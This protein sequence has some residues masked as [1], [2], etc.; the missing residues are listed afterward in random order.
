VGAGPDPKGLGDPGR[1]QSV[2]VETARSEAGRFTLVGPDAGQQMLVTGKYSSGQVRDLTRQARYS[3]APVG[4]VAVDPTG[5]VTALK[6]GEATVVVEVPPATP[7]AVGVSVTK[8]AEPP[9][10]DFAGAVVPALTKQGCNSG[11]CHGKASGQNGFKLSLFGFEPAEDY[12]YLV[13]ESRGRRLNIVAP[14]QSLLLLKPTGQ[15]A[16]GGGKRLEK[17]SPA[18]GLL[19]RWISQGAPADGPDAPIVWTIEV[20]PPERLLDRAG[21]QQLVVVAHLSDGSTADVTRLAQFESNQAELAAVS[22]RGVVTAQGL[23]GTAAVMA[24]FQTH[25]AVFRATVPL[26]APVV[27]LPPVKTFIDELVFR[28]LRELGLPPSEQ[29]D[30][31]TF[32]RRAT[33]DVAGRLPTKEETD[34]FLADRDGNKQ[35]KLIDRLLAS[36]DYADYFAGKWSAVLRNRRASDK[37]DPK[38]TFAFH[39]WIRESLAENKPYDRFV[40]EVL[41]AAGEPEQDAPVVW[42]REVKDP[43]AQVEDAAQLFLGQR[44]Q[45][46]KCH[47]H[48]L[49]KWSQQDYYGLAA[50]FSRLEVKEA[51][52][53]KKGKKGEADKLG[54]PFRVSLKPGRAQATNPRTNRAVRPAGLGGPD[55]TLPEDADPRAALADWM[56]AK[57]NPFFAK[58][59]VN[60]YWKHFLGRGLV[61]PEDDLRVTNPP[62]NLELLDALAKHFADHGY[63]LKDLVRTLCTS[64]V[65]RLSTVPNAYNAADSQN[66]SRFLTRRLQAEVL[67]D[68][69]DTVTGSKTAFTGVPP[70]TRAVQLPDNQFE[71]YFLSAFGRPD[72]ASACEC[73]RNGDASLAQALHLFNSEELLEKISGRKVGSPSPDA[74]DAKGKRGQAK[75]AG[76][77]AGPTGGRIKELL[78]DPRPDHEKVRDL[79]LTRCRGSR[80][81]RRAR[82]CSP[83]LPRRGT[84]CGAPTKTSSGRW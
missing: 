79:Y 25:V 84:T 32:L 64:Q 70:G 81:R 4:V 7:V 67:L 38:P 33:V 62:T 55:L 11:G 54:E 78:A 31:G 37:D 22:P 76:G 36:G 50:F 60:R 42:Y 59:L 69:I 17:G 5:L 80:R 52:A 14:D 46:A 66:C 13:K 82:R 9:R 6:D 61:D 41:T 1:L 83:T 53:P 47:H 28:R 16:H 35:E 44:L 57:D 58:A 10:V 74:G 71:S 40:R 45:C 29:C 56:T 21:S 34:Q 30:D 24:R 48:P 77:T 27:D 23:P 26:G 63:D 18:Y 73:E 43:A 65:Y 19:R 12:E 3:A 75:P 39:A 2:V 49:E 15:V 8:V 72:A 20:L 51:V 68:A